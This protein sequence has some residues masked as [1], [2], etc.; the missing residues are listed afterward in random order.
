[1]TRSV[2]A[3]AEGLPEGP[4]RGVPYLMKDLSAAIGGVPMT[5]GSKFFADTPPAAEDSEHVKRLRRAGLGRVAW[6][7]R[8]DAIPTSAVLRAL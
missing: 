6:S 8:Q 4:F 5:R 3:I 2:H 7:H 1:M